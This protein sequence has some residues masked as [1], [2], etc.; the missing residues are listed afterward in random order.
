MSNSEIVASLFRSEGTVKIHVGRMLAKLGLRDRVQAVVLA[1]EPRLIT[2][3]HPRPTDPASRTDTPATGACSQGPSSR[4]GGQAAAM[5]QHGDHRERRLCALVT[6]ATGG[7][8]TVAAAASSLIEQ[9]NLGIVITEEP[10]HAHF[11]AREP[12]AVAGDRRRAHACVRQRSHL[13]RL[14][15]ES[16]ADLAR[17]PTPDRYDR[18]VTV[19]G[20]AG[21]Q[22][23]EHAQAVPQD[24][25]VTEFV[26]GRDDSLGDGRVRI[27]EPGRRPWPYRGCGRLTDDVVRS[28]QQRERAGMVG[29]S[30]EYLGGTERRERHGMRP[31][32]RDSCASFESG[33]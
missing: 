23:L 25:A 17:T 15:V 3:G 12:T 32:R 19:P 6:A 31:W 26:A 27:A 33:E 24:K 13:D 8:Q 28:A 9:R 1:Y 21:Q 18:Q 20:L 16:R 7:A 5:L 29:P 10:R 4:C 2:P 11:H 14:L 30:L 22:P